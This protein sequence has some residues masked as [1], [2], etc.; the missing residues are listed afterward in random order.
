MR[1]LGDKLLVQPEVVGDKELD[2]GLVLPQAAQ[3]K[4]VKGT[5][6][7]IGPDVE[8][9]K[10]GDTVLYSQYGGVDIEFDGRDMLVL[11]TADVLLVL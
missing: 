9:L 8:I 2:S 10:D 3:G 6:V 5:V 1:V 4:P 7:A 11:R